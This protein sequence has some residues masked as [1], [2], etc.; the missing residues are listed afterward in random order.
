MSPRKIALTAVMVL[1]LAPAASASIFELTL[2][3]HSSDETP[4]ADLLATFSFDVVGTTLTLTV[5]NDTIAPN[6]F[7]MNEL[8]F[9][10]PDGVGLT[11]ITLPTDW[12]FDD[13]GSM[14]D[15]FGVFDF[16]LTNGMGE[17]DPGQIQPG[18]SL[19]FTFMI[20]GGADAK[21]FTSSFSF[22]SDPEGL[23]G[24]IAGKFVNG[25]GDDSAFGAHVP[26]PG[27]LALMGV[28]GMI[29]ARPRRRRD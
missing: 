22:Q 23:S 19:V 2:S 18:E 25:P 8:Y 16:A 21:D 20:S 12:T 14:A 26:A 29:V 3:T 7:N 27:V 11:S 24:I 13:T 17:T 28:A 6:E 10:A 5:T 4:A 1:G 9:N 15:G